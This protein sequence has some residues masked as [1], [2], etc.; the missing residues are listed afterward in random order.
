MPDDL[1]DHFTDAEI[2]QL[3]ASVPQDE[4][5]ITYKP[6]RLG[7]LVTVIAFVAVAVP[8]VAAL[9]VAVAK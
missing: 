3:R 6:V 4:E 7:D 8:M 2:R 9:V 5:F 1:R